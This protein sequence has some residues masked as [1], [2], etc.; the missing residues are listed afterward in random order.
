MYY[1]KQPVFVY[2]NGK[3]DHL[4]NVQLRIVWF[5]WELLER[6]DKAIK[7]S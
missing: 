5:M 6:L 1:H 2:R 3:A 7:A 4:R